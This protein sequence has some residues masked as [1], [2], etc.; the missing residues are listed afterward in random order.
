MKGAKSYSVKEKDKLSNEEPP[1][2]AF[3]QKQ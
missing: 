2:G 3:W 1:H